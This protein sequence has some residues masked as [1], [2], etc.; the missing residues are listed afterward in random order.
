MMAGRKGFLKTPQWNIFIV[1]VVTG[2]VVEILSIGF[3]LGW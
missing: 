2:K 1:A 3:V